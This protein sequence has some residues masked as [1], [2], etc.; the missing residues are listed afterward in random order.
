MF[1]QEPLE[2]KM[3]KLWDIFAEMLCELSQGWT[4]SYEGEAATMTVQRN[5]LMWGK[6]YQ[7]EAYDWSS[8]HCSI[9]TD[10]SPNPPTS[11]DK[12]KNSPAFPS[13]ARGR[14]GG[15]RS[16]CKGGKNIHLITTPSDSTE[17]CHSCS[18]S[19]VCTHP[20]DSTSVALWRILVL[21]CCCGLL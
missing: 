16:L 12:I 13:L 20:L 19:C 1:L 3:K 7:P 8:C 5:L 11:W 21:L 4:Q 18:T 9:E 2:E 17:I 6:W 14:Q 10:S 15:Y